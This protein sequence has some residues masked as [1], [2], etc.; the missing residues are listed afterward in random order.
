[1][2]LPTLQIFT[3]EQGLGI[4]GSLQGKPAL[5]I[6][7]GCMNHNEILYVLWINPVIFTDCGETIIIGFPYNQ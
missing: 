6:K 1:M 7:K 4:M 3:Q 2:Y 5:Y